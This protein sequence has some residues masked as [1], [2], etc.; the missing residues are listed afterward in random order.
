MV[1]SKQVMSLAKIRS[2]TTYHKL[3]QELKFW[4]YLQYHPST[5]PKNGSL[6]EMF[7]F[8]TPIIQ[9]M[10]RIS[11][12]TEQLPVQKMV[13]FNKHNN[14]RILNSFKQFCPEN[15]QVVIAYFK[16]EKR[17][18]LEARKFYNFYESIGWKLNGKNPITNWKACAQNWMIK[19]DEIKNDQNS[20]APSQIKDRFQSGRNKNYGE[21]L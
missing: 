2:R 15:E 14:K 1:S 12:E 16:S 19:A 9:K 5:S 11:S 6:V 7:R 8:D 20:K 10:D 3:L 4:G 21:P 18:S 17:G 13:T